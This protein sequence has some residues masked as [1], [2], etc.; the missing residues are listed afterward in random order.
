MIIQQ[1]NIDI[2]ICP[3][4]RHT[5][6]TARSLKN[7]FV[8]LLGAGTKTYFSN[9]KSRRPGDPGGIAI[10]IGPRWGPSY[11]CDN[12]RADHSNHGV[13]AKVQLRTETGYIAILGTYWPECLT[14]TGSGKEAGLSA[15]ELPTTNTQEPGQHLPSKESTTRDRKLWQRVLDYRREQGAH[16]P[17]PITY[18]QNLALTW[19]AKDRAD[20]CQAFILGGDFNSTWIALDRGGQRTIKKWCEDNYLINGPRLIH[21]RFAPTTSTDSGVDLHFI[22][23]GRSEWGWGTW[24]DQLLHAGDTTHISIHGAFNALGSDLDDVSDHKPLWA[25]YITAPPAEARV[26]PLPKPAKR[27]E[28]PRH[29]QRQ[30]ALFKTRISEV[31][32][33]LPTTASTL[34]DAEVAIE[35]A[36]AFSVQL[37]REIN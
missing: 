12:R 28:I 22:T 26:I 34:D 20:G 3:D 8:D 33:Q 37:T 1:D 35:M 11:I 7:L 19:I 25:A 4:S 5:T 31:V 6:S 2:M 29:D 23:W 18:L 13:L 16:D 10:I 15:A 17:S 24:I 32:S 9:D 36:T 21:D 30:I 14:T 27:P